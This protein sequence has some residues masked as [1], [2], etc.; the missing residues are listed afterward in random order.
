M[1]PGDCISEN[2]LETKH[3]VFADA[4]R[5]QPIEKAWAEPERAV[6]IEGVE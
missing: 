3:G 4:I 2:M 6:E 5:Q 1:M